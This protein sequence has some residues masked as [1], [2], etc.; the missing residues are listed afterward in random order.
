MKC[1][2]MDKGIEVCERIKVQK[3]IKNDNEMEKLKISNDR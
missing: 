3:E 1:R 2:G